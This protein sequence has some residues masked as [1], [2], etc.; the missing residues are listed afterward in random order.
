VKGAEQ[1]LG[2]EDPIAEQKTDRNDEQKEDEN[3][4]D[5]M[6]FLAQAIAAASETTVKNSTAAYRRGP[7]DHTPC[8]DFEPLQSNCTGAAHESVIER[9]R[10]EYESNR[11]ELGFN[12]NQRSTTTT[13]RK[14]WTRKT[15]EDR[16]KDLLE[17]KDIYGHCNVPVSYAKDSSLGDWCRTQ[18]KVYGYS[19][20]G[21]KK[22]TPERKELFRRLEEIG[23]KW[24]L[25]R[26]RSS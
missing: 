15:F 17:F 7:P 26:K 20:Q 4:D 6:V 11:P 24:S 23:F 18:R 5:T 8:E 19:K 14:K 3:E 16:L 9:A 1:G 21:F 10:R 22:L 2:V 25:K 13:K 12:V